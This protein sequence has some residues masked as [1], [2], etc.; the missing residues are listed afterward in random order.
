MANQFQEVIRRRAGIGSAA[1]RAEQPLLDEIF[2]A[3]SNET[4]RT[5][6]AILLAHGGFMTSGEFVDY[7]DSSWPTISRHLRVLEGAGLVEYETRGRDHAYTLV[8]APLDNVVG[9]W[10]QCFAGARRPE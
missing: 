9:P 4:R 10:T 6:L 8:A 5:I 7:F 2:G 1:W 3:L